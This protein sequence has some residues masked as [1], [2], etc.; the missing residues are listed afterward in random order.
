MLWRF[1]VNSKGFGQMYTWIL[2]PPDSPPIQAATW[3]WAESHVLYRR[4][5]A[6]CTCPFTDHNFLNWVSPHWTV[7]VFLA[8][9]ILTTAKQTAL[10]TSVH[11]VS[12][13]FW[14]FPRLSSR[15]QPQHCISL[16]VTVLTSL[17][18]LSSAGSHILASG[19]VRIPRFMLLESGGLQIAPSPSRTQAATPATQP[20][21]RAPWT[22]PPCSPCG[23]RT[24]AHA[25]R[26]VTNGLISTSSALGDV[27]VP[28][29]S[30]I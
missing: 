25:G 27:N 28:L 17:F 12:T 2:S 19:S 10:V 21:Q 23:V 14:L 13:F 22:R 5:T 26:S 1:P 4:K 9:V 6:E 7:R 8:S 15:L 29:D 11:I 30:L 20:T 16:N 18:S 24:A 3:G